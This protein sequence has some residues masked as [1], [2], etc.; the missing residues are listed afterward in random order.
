[1]EGLRR[2]LALFTGAV[3]IGW[4]LDRLWD[5]AFETVET[6]PVALHDEGEHAV[7]GRRVRVVSILN[8][9]PTTVWAKVT[10]PALLATVAHPL[11]TFKRQDG[12]PLPEVW[13]EGEALHLDLFGLGCI[14]LGAHMIEVARIDAEQREIRSR[15]SGRIAEIWRHTITL[16]DAPGGRTRYTDIIDI[17]AGALT[18]AVA[19]FARF[20]YRYRQTRWRAV[21]RNRHAD[22]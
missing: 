4:L 19:A 16:N 9:P 11:L 5:R 13:R 20:F 7:R 10:T 1:M 22:G 15:E 17:Y 3:L 12:A 18:G 14:P 6:A 8:A 21:L 2:T